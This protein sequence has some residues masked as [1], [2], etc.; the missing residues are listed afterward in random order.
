MT[1]NL[2][3]DFILKSINT[4]STL[5]KNLCFKGV[6]DLSLATRN[7]LVF[8]S[9]IKY[10][11]LLKK[12]K[13]LGCFIKENHVKF[14]PENCFPI[15]SNNPEIDFIKVTNLFYKKLNLDQIA[16][17]VLNRSGIKKKFKQIVFGKNF[18][19][20][21][22]VK[23]G[24]NCVIGHNVIIDSSVIEENT[25][26]GNNVVLSNSFVGKNVNICDSSVIGKKGF[27]FKVIDNKIIRIPHIGKVIIGDNCEIGSKCNIDRGSIR[28]TIIKENTFIDN[29]VQIAHNVNIGANC[30]IAS[31][32]GI[33]GSTTIGDNTVIGGQAGISGHLRIGRN[34]K[35]GG[36]SGVIR[37]L[38]DN[39]RVMGYPAINFKSFIKKN[40]QK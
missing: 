4:K 35:I 40:I 29:M 16:I 32:V 10:L 22:N 20:G 8:F 5:K 39:T 17:N 7:D 3:L 19:C 12:T 14:L 23:I 31:Q 25:R 1:K 37:N 15:I 13:A 9:N 38:D 34:V 2:K 28:D 21:Q 30:I 26:I 11:D 33:A 6:S 36:K 27:G 24:K 18:I